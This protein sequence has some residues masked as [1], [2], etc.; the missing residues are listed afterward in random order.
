[1]PNI[2]SN[3]IVCTK[4]SII[5]LLAFNN[6]GCSFIISI[7]SL[8]LSLSV[9]HDKKTFNICKIAKLLSVLNLKTL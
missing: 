6:N 2:I 8:S 3:G 9:S 5:L 1:M 7:Y 4:H